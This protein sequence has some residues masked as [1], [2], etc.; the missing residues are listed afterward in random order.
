M[1]PNILWIC[2]DQQR[3]DTIGALGNRVIQTPNLDALCTAGTAFTRAY[4]QSP[5]CTPS[6][7]SFLTGRYP[8]SVGVNRNGIEAPPRDLPLITR[9][10][11]REGYHCG[12]VGKL[13][14][15]SA[16]HRREVRCDDGYTEFQYSHS[17]F[18]L[19]AETNEYLTWLEE[20][21]ISP[22]DV[23]EKVAGRGYYGYKADLDPALHQTSWCQERAIDFIKRNHDSEQ[24]WL[25]SVNFFDPHPPFD[26]PASLTARFDGLDL[27]EP[28]WDER[29]LDTLAKL[30]GAF[31]QTREPIRPSADSRPRIAS[32]YAMVELVDRAVGGIVACL[33][34][35]GA[36][37]N[38]LIIFNSDHGEMCGDHGLVL[39]GCRFYDQAVRIPLIM[40]LPGIIGR[41]VVR[42]EP[43]E[44]TD[45]VPTLCEL[46]GIPDL[47]SD[48][49]SLVPLLRT[50][51]HGN[52]IWLR[53]GVRCEYYDALPV[54]D[55]KGEFRRPGSTATMIYD[56][57]Y[58]LSYY[59]H[60]NTGELYDLQEDPEEVRD[61][62]DSGTCTEIRFHLLAEMLNFAS[63]TIDDGIPVIGE[64]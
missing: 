50:A 9:R 35:T 2:T 37:E 53:R 11:A 52:P 30:K 55:S 12:L 6:R 29:E 22:E 47:P 48:G 31:H 49:Y 18:N 58:K 45:I 57:R 16:E 51:D 54:R 64:Y 5:V 24:P 26:A 36:L 40:V 28:I 60:L 8:Y 33:D 20:K 34:R 19:T 15:A 46:C 21:G 4:C 59:H 39:K 41:G 10:L 44:L 23:F 63:Y 3:F 14:L 27:P 17:P 43:V 25:L 32:Y 56:G 7:A 13:H 1:R 62:W 42:E 38:T 61:L